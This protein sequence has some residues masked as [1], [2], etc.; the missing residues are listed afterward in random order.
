MLHCTVGL[1]C[2]EDDAE[3]DDDPVWQI[4]NGSGNQ[5]HVLRF[6]GSAGSLQYF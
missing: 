3:D 6:E 2:V 1:L 4:W 5:Y